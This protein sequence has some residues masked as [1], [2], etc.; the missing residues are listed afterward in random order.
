MARRLVSIAALLVVLVIAQTSCGSEQ[1]ASFADVEGA[2]PQLAYRPPAP[3]HPIRVN[4]YVQAT[5]DMLPLLSDGSVFREVFTVLQTTA[6]D[7]WGTGRTSQ[8]MFRFD[9][10]WQENR[11]EDGYVR[12]AYH[13]AYPL[14]P[15][16]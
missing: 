11:G 1:D 13:F 9:A 6:V 3:N 15:H 4:I 2:F 14:D 10:E 5:Y 8:H 16:W 12:T 7:L